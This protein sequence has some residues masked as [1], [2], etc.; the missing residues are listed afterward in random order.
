MDEY[1]NGGNGWEPV[2]AE[3]TIVEAASGTM[4]EPVFDP[5]V[6][7]IALCI[8]SFSTPPERRDRAARLCREG[9]RTPRATK[10]ST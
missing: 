3:M 1:P 6:D 4:P 8:N 2:R 10:A 9:A 5:V 7:Y